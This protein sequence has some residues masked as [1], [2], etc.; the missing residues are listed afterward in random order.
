MLKC[1]YCK[2]EFTIK[3]ALKKHQTKTLY[4]LKIQ[5]KQTSLTC[6]FCSKVL[7]SKK[8]LEAHDIICNRRIEARYE[9]LIQGLNYSFEEKKKEYEIEIQK[10]D[11]RIKELEN[12]LDTILMGLISKPTCVRNYILNIDDKLI[13]NKF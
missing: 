11:S 4:C 9:G 7:Q 1:E 6:S 5:E 8:K 3:S 2:K 10:K 13:R 12:K